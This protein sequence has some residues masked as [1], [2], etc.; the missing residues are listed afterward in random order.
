MFLKNIGISGEAKINI[1]NI[2]GNIV[3]NQS[4]FINKEEVVSFY[5][6]DLVQGVYFVEIQQNHIKKTHIFCRC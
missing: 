5:L 2:Y 6:K 4:I 1:I 3:F